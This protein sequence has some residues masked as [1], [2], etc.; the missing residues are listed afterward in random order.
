MPRRRQDLTGERFGKLK[1]VDYAGYEKNDRQNVSMWNCQCD[2][3]NT[4]VVSGNLLRAGRKKSCGCLRVTKEKLAGLRFGKLTVLEEDKGDATTL[5]KVICQCDCGNVKSIAF[6][7]LKNGRITDCGCERVRPAEKYG[8]F[9]RYYDEKLELKRRLFASGDYHEICTLKDWVYVWLREILPGVV[10]QTTQIMYGETMERH[11]L[12]VLGDKK[13]RD[14]MP[15]D[16]K[17]WLDYLRIENVPG[18]VNETMTEGTVRNTLSVLSGCMRDAQRYGLITQNPCLEPSWT[19]QTR[20]INESH[21][22]LTEEQIALLE[23]LLLQYQS[24][25]GYPLGIGFQLVLYTGLLMSEAVALRWKDIDFSKKTLEVR[26][27]V[28]LTK[29]LES[30][31]LDIEYHLEKAVGRRRREVPIPNVFLKKLE[32]VHRKFPGGEE[33]FVLYSPD[34]KVVRLD[35]MRSA[36][37]RKGKS[38]GIEKVTPQMLRDTYAMRAVEAGATSDV[39]AELM[40]FA[41]SQQVVRRYMPKRTVD[42]QELV[43]RMYG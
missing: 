16:V 28:S 9:E 2:C 17:K 31:A 41:S 36:L 10:K 12:P 22:W 3:G 5:R 29:S 24:E 40:G 30:T 25:E 35:R 37:M 27:F 7:D 26:Y 32:E 39:I 13:L 33:D 21:E 8:Y 19:L 6:R 34:H 15:S 23:P 4:C 11:I 43:N 14:I 20:N 38:A 18:T 42:K 1:V